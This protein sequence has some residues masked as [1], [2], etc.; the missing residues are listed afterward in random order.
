MINK[1][2]FIRRYFLIGGL[3]LLTIGGISLIGYSYQDSGNFKAY[4]ETLPGTDI[5]FQMVPVPGGT[6]MMGSP[7]SEK[8]REKDEG[9]VHKVKVDP[10]WMGKHEVTWQEYEQFVYLKRDIAAG[11]D[12]EVDGFSSPTP[13]YVDMSFGM[14]KNGYPAINMTQYAALNYCLWLTAKTGDF[15]RLPTEAEWEYACRA[16][17]QTAYHFGDDPSQL[18]DYAW[19][20]KNSDG[21]YE[22]VGRKKPNQWGLHDMHGN[23]AEWTLDQYLPQ[24]KVTG[25]VMVNP[26]VE[27]TKLYP[28]VVRGGSWDDDAEDLR[29]AARMASKSSWKRRDPQ[30]PKSNWWMTDASFV[31]FR[32]VRPLKQPSKAEIREYFKKPIQDF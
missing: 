19:Y 6:F 26:V 15:Y 18:K 10:F 27:A 8:G 32:I 5:D 12:T 11:D 20:Y 28:H 13:P 30:I 21:G 22:K 14:G 4:T 2:N 24:Y 16:G 3:V 17:T 29:S 9:P 1:M 25:D 7:E 31:G 23:V